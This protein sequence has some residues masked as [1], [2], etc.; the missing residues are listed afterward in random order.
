LAD[1]YAVIAYYL[2]HRDEVQSYYVGEELPHKPE[3]PAKGD[4]S[5][6]PQACDP[7]PCRGNSLPGA[8]KKRKRCAARSRSRSLP[9]RASGKS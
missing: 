5:L 2:R 9:G 7:L 1:V 3:A 4:P 8:G 6:A